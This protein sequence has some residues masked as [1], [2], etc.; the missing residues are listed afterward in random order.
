M[1]GNEPFVLG[2]IQTP[3]LHSL[4]ELPPLLDSA[5]Q[6]AE[7]HASPTAPLFLLPELFLGGFAYDTCSAIAAQTPETLK[8]LQ[9]QAQRRNLVLGGSFWEAAGSSYKNS[10]WLLGAGLQEP[11]RVRSK[12]RLFPLSDEERHFRAGDA[13]LQSFELMGLRCGLGIC[14]EL[15]FP[16]IFRQQAACGM[17][18]LLL[19]SQW[20]LSRAMHLETLSRARAIENQCFLLSCNACG[21]SMLGVLAGGSRCFSPW[22]EELFVCGQE[23]TVA[24]APC[25]LQSV[26]RARAAFDTRPQLEK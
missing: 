18:L 11:R 7:A 4:S 2:V 13:S 21:P 8:Q 9:Q 15:R 20:P 24:C 6:K 5:A 22:G 12:Q 25:S 3:V 19:S 14:F 1:R 23:P 10:F 17:E 26:E 16:E